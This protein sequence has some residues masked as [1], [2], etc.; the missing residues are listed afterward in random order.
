MGSDIFR[1]LVGAQDFPAISR[2][3][4]SPERDGAFVV[5]TT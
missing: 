4:S 5:S 2:L 3:R 1:S